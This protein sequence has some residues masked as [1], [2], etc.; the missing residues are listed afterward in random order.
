MLLPTLILLAS[1]PA[2]APPTDITKTFTVPA[3]NFSAVEAGALADGWQPKGA[4]AIVRDG[5]VI[6]Y[7]VCGNNLELTIEAKPFYVPVD[8]IWR[9]IDSW[10]WAKP[11]STKP[12]AEAPAEEF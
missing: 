1:C 5:I 3:A 4:S 9:D 8:A 10:V 2:I 7:V 11:T 12:P 6:G